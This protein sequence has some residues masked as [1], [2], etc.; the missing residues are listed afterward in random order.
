VKLPLVR[1]SQDGKWA[2]CVGCGLRFARRSEVVGW[3]DFLPGWVEDR[4]AAAIP[5]WRMSARAWKRSSQGRQASF[6]RSPTFDIG[7][8]KPGVGVGRE[9]RRDPAGRLWRF[10]LR[11]ENLPAIVICPKC[12]KQ[13]LADPQALRLI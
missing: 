13:Q 9:A 7:Q 12:L 3:I 8:E 5:V 1:L 2:C 10:G 6:R 11:A 4:N